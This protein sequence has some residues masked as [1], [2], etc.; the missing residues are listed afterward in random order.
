MGRKQTVKEPK[1]TLGAI[2]PPEFDRMVETMATAMDSR[3]KGWLGARFMVR[4]YLAVLEGERLL[5][6]EEIKEIIADRS[7]FERVLTGAKELLTSGISSIRPK[8]FAPRVEA[9]TSQLSPQEQRSL[10]EI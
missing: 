7:E 1:A 5:S 3:A 8:L 10:A 6:D 9:A 4:G 2:V